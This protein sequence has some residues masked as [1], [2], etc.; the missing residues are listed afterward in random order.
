[1]PYCWPC[2]LTPPARLPFLLATLHSLSALASF[3]P[4]LFRRPAT[5]PP[6]SLHRLTFPLTCPSPAAFLYSPL[7]SCLPAPTSSLVPPLS[8]CLPDPPSQAPSAPPAHPSLLY[9]PRSWCSP[10]P[11]EVIAWSCSGRTHRARARC[12]GAAL[13][14]RKPDSPTPIFYTATELLTLTP[15]TATPTASRSLLESQ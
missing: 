1:M 2:K 3:C 5:P 9:V 8:C 7:L 13:N 11:M 6:L 14:T 12:A 10:T 4:L 15:D